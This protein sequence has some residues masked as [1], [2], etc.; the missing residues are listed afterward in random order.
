MFYYI[1]GNLEYRDANTCVVDCGGV[2]YQMTVSLLTSE[3][4][5]SKLNQRVKLY[6]YLAVR[7]DGIELFGFGTSEE[8]ACFSQL[9]TVSGV[10]PKAAISILSS[11]SP[12]GG[13][14]MCVAEKE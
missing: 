4:L 7:E 10:G 2:G 12:I 13:K 14:S 6:T 3:S 8:K 9:I 11:M 5:A 1:S